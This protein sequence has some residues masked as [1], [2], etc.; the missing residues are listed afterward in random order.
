MWRF[1]LVLG[2]LL[3][4]AGLV[5]MALG[6]AIFVSSFGNTLIA[7][8]AV[9][10]SSGI[11]LVAVAQVLRHVI[12]LSD[13]MDAVLNAI[14]GVAAPRASR[15]PAPVAADAYDEPEL[16][17]EDEL[18][19]DP[20]PV[21][22]PPAP[23]PAPA[24]AFPAFMRPK[25]PERAPERAP[26]PIAAPDV[27]LPD[28][29]EDYDDAP[30]LK[31]AY[32]PTAEVDQRR[33]RILGPMG[34]DHDAPDA[35]QPAAPARGRSL[36]ESFSPLSRPA[37]TPA[38]APDRAPAPRPAPPAPS[39]DRPLFDRPTLERPVSE[40]AP[41][42][43]GPADRFFAERPLSERAASERP[44]SER[45]PLDRP[46]P[47]PRAPFERSP[48]ERAPLERSPLDRAPLD[49]APLDRAPSDQAPADRS[50]DR[51]PPAPPQPFAP[52]PATA[53]PRPFGAPAADR[54]DEPQP[55]PTILKSGVVG[56]MAYTLYSDGSIQAEL[57]DGVLRFNSLQELRD[58]VARAGQPPR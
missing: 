28:L 15:A 2:F 54:W 57:P 1:L 4:L 55:E 24:R 40:R 8:G 53:A 39:A 18:D 26:E 29:D 43:R 37:Q 6:V 20:E 9:G 21:A 50:E 49:R 19:A 23:A 48:L 7:V 41:T 58:H 47:P 10:L 34:E 11:L 3:A 44:A 16:D 13:R 22:P 12:E 14:S 32:A 27:D 51:A 52:A 17:F 33:G 36:F 56:G 35:E 38:Q 5:V 45:A 46:V 42:E 30:E 31:P 25:A